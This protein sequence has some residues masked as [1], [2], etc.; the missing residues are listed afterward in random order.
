MLQ[1][2]QLSSWSS[3]GKHNTIEQAWHI[4]VVGIVVGVE[5]L[6]WL[7][8]CATSASWGATSARVSTAA[9]PL[10]PLPKGFALYVARSHSMQE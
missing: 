7:S 2:V 6:Q 1:L 3:C 5:Q 9:N 10:G 8:F 4:V